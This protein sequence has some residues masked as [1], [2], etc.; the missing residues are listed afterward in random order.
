MKKKAFCVSL[1]A[2]VIVL[3]VSR[4]I[5]TGTAQAEPSDT[6]KVVYNTL[7]NS[8]TYRSAQAVYHES[9]SSFEAMLED[10]NITFTKTGENDVPITWVFVQNGDWLT[11]PYGSE[12]ESSRGCASMLLAAAVSA[13][14]MN[15]DLFFGYINA[16]TDLQS[17]YYEESET[18]NRVSVNI[19]TA[20]GHGRR[21]RRQRPPCPC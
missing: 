3:L 21:T 1:L 7:V 12:E 4:I 11:A 15:E 9:G 14:G 5:L 8:R 17:K 16:L 13:Q 18:E 20:E 2:L 19:V 6:L 10:N